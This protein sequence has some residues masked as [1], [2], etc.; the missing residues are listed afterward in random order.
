MQ[1][2][3]NLK[4]IHSVELLLLGGRVSAALANQVRV[5]QTRWELDRLRDR[6]AAWVRRRRGLDRLGQYQTQL[7]ALE[8][9]LLGCLDGVEAALDTIDGSRPLGEV[10][11]DCRAADRRLALVGRVWEWFRSKFDQRDDPTLGP[12]LAAADEVVWSC[13]AEVFRNAAQMSG[14]EVPS[15]PAPLPYIEPSYAPRA[16]VRDEPPAELRADAG[17]AVLREFL[18]R[19]P[20]PVVGLPSAC[21][22]AP[23]WLVLLGHEVGHQVQSDLV[24]DWGLVA[25]FGT[26]LADAAGD[27]AAGR[28]RRWAAEVFAD[29]CLLCCAGP[30]AVWAMVELELT[31][32]RAMLAG[33]RAR[34]PSP[35]ARLELLAVAAGSLGLDGRAGLRGLD[36][37]S[38]AA[39]GDGALLEHAAED[40]A[41][42]AR[43]AAAA[44]GH[45]LGGLGTF[46]ELYA[47]D[48]GDFRQGGAVDGWAWALR[49]PGLLFPEQ[50]LRAARLLVCG[51]I[52]AWS[53]VASNPDA[54]ERSDA[55]A[56]LREALL[57]MLAQ[58]REE[59]TRAAEPS[60]LPD[61]G[62]LTQDLTK[63]LLERVR[64]RPG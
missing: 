13:Y 42:A 37:R 55:R 51:A 52:A 14:R 16:V 24:P 17:D 1:K 7:L 45:R 2:R 28:W 61:L 22:E 47:F 59:A 32:D 30:W 60:T 31:D 50:S 29:L 27:E 6:I 9:A 54:A 39:G 15:G 40:V 58:S 41:L 35:V 23:W 18:A 38:L 33:N 62:N 48:A 5:E 12:V 20:I 36:P 43:M 63:L 25:E 19:L 10:Y 44:L 34:Y 3:I 26:L 11:A 57:P 49:R 56:G 4:R 53:Q 21:V 64:D 8:T 46:A